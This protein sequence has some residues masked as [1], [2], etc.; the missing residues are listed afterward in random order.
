MMVMRTAPFA[1]GKRRQRPQAYSRDHTAGFRCPV[2]F[3]MSGP[4]AA[5]VVLHRLPRR[6]PAANGLLHA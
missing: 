5:K 3:F 2:S 4:M 1:L 6:F